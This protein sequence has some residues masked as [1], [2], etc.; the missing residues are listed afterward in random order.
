MPRQLS[1]ILGEL[2]CHPSAVECPVPSG[3]PSRLA[4]AAPPLF[5]TEDSLPIQI[6]LT[7]SASDN[8][9]F[10]QTNMKARFIAPSARLSISRRPQPRT[11]RVGVVT[12]SQGQG[13]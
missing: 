4:A 5:V 1:G 2:I 7:R 12:S 13:A 11:G 10:F 3:A 9:P 6:V 8:S